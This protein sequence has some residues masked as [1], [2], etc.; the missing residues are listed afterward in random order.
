MVVGCLL[1]IVGCLLFVYLFV[2]WFVR[3]FVC[4]LFVLC[5]F[6]FVLFVCVFCAVS[7]L[8]LSS[9]LLSSS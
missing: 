7:L 6:C 2:C 9:S 8:L 4:L 1:L 3:S 5:R